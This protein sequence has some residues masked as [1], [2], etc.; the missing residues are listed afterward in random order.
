MSA[1]M[2]TIFIPKIDLNA[3]PDPHRDLP[4]AVSQFLDTLSNEG[5]EILDCNPLRVNR[6]IV[7]RVV[8]LDGN[9][10]ALKERYRPLVREHGL[11]LYWIYSRRLTDLGASAV[12][13]F[14]GSATTE[15][16]DA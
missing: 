7:W 13:L 3:A 6:Q 9:A 1:V 11:H 5:N 8:F 15:G 4:S 16:E 12:V 10:I 14:V 2:R